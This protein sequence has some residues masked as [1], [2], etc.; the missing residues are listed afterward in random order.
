MNNNRN[1]MKSGDAFHPGEFI[2]DELG[3]REMKQ[4]ELADDMGISKTVLSQIIHGKRNIT[5]II[6]LKLEQSP[7]I[8]AELWMKLQVRYELNTIRLNQMDALKKAKIQSK[9][10]PDIKEVISVA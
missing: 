7:G 9:K 4:Q 10:K 8:N 5:P 6:A 2:K 1:E 3:A